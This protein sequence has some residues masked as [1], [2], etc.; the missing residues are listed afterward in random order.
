MKLSAAIIYY[1][2]Q[3]SY[4]LGSYS[5]AGTKLSLKRPLLW[6]GERS[7]EDSRVYILAAPAFPEEYSAND[8]FIFCG[9][10][11][12]ILPRCDYI[13]FAAPQVVEQILNDLQMIFDRYLEWDDHLEEVCLQGSA[14]EILEC[15]APVFENMLVLTDVGFH[16]IAF[17][18]SCTQEGFCLPPRTTAERQ[19]RLKQ[20]YATKCDEEAPFTIP[21]DILGFEKLACNFFDNGINIGSLTIHP[22]RQ[23]I[24]PQDCALLSHVRMRMAARWRTLAPLEC[25]EKHLSKLLRQ[26]LEGERVEKDY[27]LFAL[28]FVECADPPKFRC[29]MIRLPEEWKREHLLY[30]QRRLSQEPT[31]AAFFG[32]QSM[33]YILQSAAG[34]EGEADELAGL[35]QIL[36]AIELQAGISDSFEDISLFPYYCTEA[37]FA[38]ERERK[39]ESDRMCFFSS[40]IGDYILENCCGKLRREMIYPAGFR[41]LIDHDIHGK[42]SYVGTLKTYLDANMNALQAAAK[43][44]ISRNTLIARM[45]HIQAILG[46]DLD[47]PDNRFLLA[48]CIKLY[49]AQNAGAYRNS[50]R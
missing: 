26:M 8:L 47:D 39:S 45:S 28:N 16:I 13:C 50:L 25:S 27:L 14:Q 23:P 38:L 3:N 31:A 40:C 33:F 10:V 29:V 12:E 43:L 21:Q 18:S 35:E 15:S 44:Y 17:T 46:L 34:D 22:S 1:E 2:L 32:Y 19:A 6:N 7:V 24:R 48:L 36:A 30:L 41:S 5:C 20:F 42:I 37:S 4:P 9:E 11:P 49:Y